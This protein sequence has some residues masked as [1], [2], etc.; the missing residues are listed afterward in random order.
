MD[1]FEDILI[2]ALKNEYKAYKRSEIF[3]KVAEECK[4][5]KQECEDMYKKYILDPAINVMIVQR[6]Q[7]SSVSC[8]AKVL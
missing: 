3:L 1:R 7:Q 8:K 5:S 2:L 6:M 4:L